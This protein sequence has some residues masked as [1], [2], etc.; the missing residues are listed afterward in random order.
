M[1]AYKCELLVDE[2][3]DLIADYTHE[4]STISD[5]RLVGLEGQERDANMK[6][7]G[8]YNTVHCTRVQQIPPSVIP[9]YT[10]KDGIISRR[11]VLYNVLVLSRKTAYNVPKTFWS[12]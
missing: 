12:E 10:F 7:L 11:T 5:V 2:L 4:Y 6:Y 1:L 8:K 3:E 9:T